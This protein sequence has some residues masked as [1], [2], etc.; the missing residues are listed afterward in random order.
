M[1]VRS[2][3]VGVE[4][5]LYALMNMERKIWNKK[6]LIK[7]GKQNIEV[8]NYGKTKYIKQ[9]I[10]VAKY[11]KQEIETKQRSG[12]ISKDKTSKRLDIEIENY[13]TQNIHVVKY[14]TRNIE[15]AKYPTQN[16]E[17]AKYRN[18]KYRR[19]KRALR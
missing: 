12:K 7:Y 17:V 18:T 8:A 13:Q 10:E 15:V 4:G 19:T 16:I 6:K 3:T 5:R 9:N 1:K 2:Q 14:R 11:R